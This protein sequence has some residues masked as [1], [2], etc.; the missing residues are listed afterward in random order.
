VFLL[1]TTPP[2]LTAVVWMENT[3]QNLGT[4]FWANW[5]AALNWLNHAVYGH[6]ERLVRTQEVA[7]SSPASSIK[8]NAC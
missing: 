3:L 4:R 5:S 6:R 2:C 7:G 8:R 1:T